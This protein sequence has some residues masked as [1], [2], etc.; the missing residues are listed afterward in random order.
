LPDTTRSCKKTPGTLDLFE[1]KLYVACSD[2]WLE[3]IQVQL[4]GKKPV[5]GADFARGA[6]NFSNLVLK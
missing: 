3:L 4:E 1:K 2:H 6:Q 5:S